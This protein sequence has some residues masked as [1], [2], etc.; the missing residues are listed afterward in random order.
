MQDN[1]SGKHETR[2]GR[3]QYFAASFIIGGALILCALIVS[4]TAIKVKSLGQSITVTGAAYRPITSNYGIWSGTIS[5]IEPT[6]S[7]AYEKL[8]K[9]LETANNFLAEEGYAD[10]LREVGA[11]RIW[12]KENREGALMSYSLSQT[13]TVALADVDRIEQLAKDASALIERGVELNSSNPRYLFT[14]LDRKSVV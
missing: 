13:V 2:A 12:R 4:H 6:L 5:V 10:S 8:A 1:S 11:V 9:D 14:R 7:G 3:S